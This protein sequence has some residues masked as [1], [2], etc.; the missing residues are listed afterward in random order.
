MSGENV[1][2]IIIVLAIMF[3]LFLAY[4]MTLGFSGI[5]V[6]IGVLI[7]GIVMAYCKGKEEETQKNDDY[8]TDEDFLHVKVGEWVSRP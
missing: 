5:F 8:F 6:F 7:G 4:T 2:T 3:M 1:M